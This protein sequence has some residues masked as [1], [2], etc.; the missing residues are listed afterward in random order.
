MSNTNSTSFQF[1]LKKNHQEVVHVDSSVHDLLGYNSD[2]FIK[3]RIQFSSLI[4]FDDQNIKRELFS[5]A[6]QNALNK[7]NFR[8]RHANGKI[9][10]L[11]ANYKKQFDQSSNTLKLQ[12]QLTDSKLLR[13]P[14]DDQILMTNFSAM[15][16]NTDD[17]IYFKD[18]NHV[19][20][21]ASQ[22]LVDL[23]PPSEYWKDLLGKTDYDVF[24][25]VYADAYYRLEKQVFSGQIQV[26]H[27]VQEI[28]NT[29][30][31]RGWVDNR[32]YPIKDASG[33]IIGLFG[34]ARDITENKLL[35][36]ALRESEEHFRTIFL[37]APLGVAVI[38]SFTGHIYDANPAYALIV[39]RS[40]EELKT[41]NWM[42]IT[43]PDDVQED[44]DNMAS[45]NAGET[46][47]FNIE[48]RYIQPDGTVSWINVT[49]AKM[50]VKDKNK[51]R[52]L[53]MTEN[54]TQRKA[55]ENEL[56][57]AATVFQNTEQAI[58]ITD[59][60]NLIIAT[61]P[62]FSN[63]TGYSSTEVMGKDPK[64]LQSGRHDNEFYDQ[65]MKRINRTGRWQ[66]ELWN[67][68]KNG[69]EFAESLSINSIYD[70][71]GN[72]LQ[73]VSLFSDITEKKRAIEKIWQQ[74]NFDPLTQLPNRNM[75]SDRL[76]QKIK[77]SQRTAKPLALLFL[78]LD[79][80][81]EVNDALGHYKGDQLLIEAAKR[82]RDCVRDSDT[83]SRLG[84]DE[85]TVILSELDDTLHIERI[86]QDIIE[87]LNM[88]FTLGIEEAHVSASIGIALY[89]NDTNKI[90]TLIKYA[91]Q[92]MYLAKG[93]GRN[94][95]S[96][97]TKSIQV[98]A[99]YRHQLMIDLHF[100]LK[101]KQFELYYQPIINLQS[102]QIVKAEALLRWVHPTRGMV[103]PVEFI[104]LAE[105]SG[106]IIDI[107][108]WVFQ[109]VTKQIKD[110][111]QN[112]D[113]NIQIS[114]NKSS[115]QFR[116][117]T[118][119]LDW[120]D[121]LNKLGIKRNSLVIEII[122]SLLIDN[123]DT[124]QK[125]LLGFRDNGIQ[126]AIDDFGT[127]YSALSYLNKLDINYLKIDRSFISNLA[128]GSNELVLC[129]AI[130][131]MAHKL[132][133]KVIAEGIETE[134]QQQLLINAGCDFGQGFLFYKPVPSEDF[135]KLLVRNKSASL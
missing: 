92:A 31:N 49:I 99:R 51:P 80:F 100:A 116:S 76:S 57:L 86:A 122:E 8:V 44:L 71:N 25:E 74:A 18:R 113:F 118:G 55:V 115:V 130:I 45:M 82:I 94:Q 59:K 33:N 9:V 14:L 124:V 132:G 5:L 60:N 36:Q 41:I 47:G 28:V 37:E 48:K 108:N 42:E 101:E 62:A 68:K 131:V 39:G 21:G 127:G 24:P 63:V 114:I 6:S 7:I 27:E 78:D 56:K 15:M 87:T 4:H 126:V 34:I 61:N 83:V 11:Q 102:D 119:Y 66:G 129:E 32:K 98:Q 91:D 84:G 35:E 125:Q 22:T 95:F 89:P 111:Q 13:K 67:K 96:F 135:E 75:F 117:I 54:I 93:N 17:Y 97:F 81:K 70:D 12:L 85:F 40:I 133:I 30:G 23:T 46:T 52:H 128:L 26:A 50:Q 109:Q 120:I 65:M 121:H 3:L 104:P 64:I 88:P 77:L 72:L 38:D 112:Q 79:H 110:W 43:H 29:Q 73:R 19:F 105:E 107:G 1:I 58:T 103:S 2:E 69:T 90:D 20:T 134:E 16:E 10:C 53:C 106:L 123:A